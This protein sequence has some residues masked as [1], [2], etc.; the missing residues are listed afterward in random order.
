MKQ[1]KLAAATYPEWGKHPFQEIDVARYIAPEHVARR[2]EAGIRL[3]PGGDYG[4]VWIPHGEAARD[5]EHFVDRC[6]ISAKDAVMT[7]THHF[8]GLTGWRVGQLKP[9]YFADML[10]LDGDPTLDVKLLQDWRRR[11][12]VI[13]GG[14]VAWVHPE[15]SGI[16]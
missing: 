14:V 16:G 6:G 13:K 2:A 9:G 11:R 15:R 12:A 7:A 10:I 5:L 1:A 8:G 3:L 4:H